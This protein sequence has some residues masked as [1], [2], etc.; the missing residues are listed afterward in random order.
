MKRKDNPFPGVSRL[1]D[2]HGKLRWRF[3]RLHKADTY[4][5]G[6]YGSIEFRQ[7]YESAL[8][9]LATPR[10]NEAAEGTLAWLITRYMK[11]S[12]YSDL[13][14]SRKK[15]LRRELEWLRNEAG[16]LP[17]TRF[18]TRH[19]EALMK[20]KQG[21]TAANTVKK[22]LSLLFN[23][24]IHDS[25]MGQRLNPA[26][27]AYRRKE[28]E[29]GY[30][31]WTAEEV[32]QY[33]AYHP[34]GRKSRLAMTIFLYTG[35]SR[36]DAAALGPSNWKDGRIKYAR[37]KTGVEVDLPVLPDLA[38]ELEAVARTQ[39]HFLAHSDGKPYKPETLGNWF[40]EQCDAA[41]LKVCSAHGLRKAGATRLAEA[42]ATEWEIA[43]YLGHENTKMAAVYVNQAQRGILS[44]NGMAKLGSRGMNGSGKSQE[45]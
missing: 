15:S 21:P 5:P 27:A 8:R 44:D 33:T 24:A 11:T 43:S 45:T 16:D 2:R 22:N 7:A 39:T 10:V 31:T 40:R 19:V 30:H 28:A 32:A 13:S 12:R 35:A 1:I 18:E 4:L 37:G 3:R 23:H 25:L 41:G 20:K 9:G 36:Q 38:T 17:F 29:G 42:G 6:A 34:S 14:D 26:K